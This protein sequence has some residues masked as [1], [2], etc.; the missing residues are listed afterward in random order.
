MPP[1]AIANPHAPGIGE[2]IVGGAEWVGAGTA[3]PNH[4]NLAEEA[5]WMGADGRR[6]DGE[7][8]GD[9]GPGLVL[10]IHDC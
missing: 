7:D 3:V 9:D 2:T 1:P 6:V 5:S 10:G 4:R 8:D